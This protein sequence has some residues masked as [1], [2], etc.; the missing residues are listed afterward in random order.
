[1]KPFVFSKVFVIEP[2]VAFLNDL[3]SIFVFY[4]PDA[5]HYQ[6]AIFSMK[7][8]SVFCLTSVVF[9]PFCLFVLLVFLFLL[10]LLRTGEA[11][12]C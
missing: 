10:L 6:V 5:V 2:L 3:E 8:F 12:Q 1:M 9:F 7:Y 11:F 4:F